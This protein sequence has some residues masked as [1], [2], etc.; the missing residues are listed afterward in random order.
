MKAYDEITEAIDDPYDRWIARSERK[1]GER[2]A[3]INENILVRCNYCGRYRP[4]DEHE[5]RGC[6]ASNG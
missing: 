4:Y 3:K 2:A 6:G 1:W 5:C